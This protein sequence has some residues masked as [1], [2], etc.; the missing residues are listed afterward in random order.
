MLDLAGSWFILALQILIEFLFCWGERAW[1]REL[2]INCY[3]IGYLI[4][5]CS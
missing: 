3:T 5:R 4:L 1:P 2:T